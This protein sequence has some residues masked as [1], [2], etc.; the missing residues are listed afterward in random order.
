[1][2][3]LTEG[4]IVHYVARKNADHAPALIVRVVDRDPVRVNL[5][6][7]ASSTTQASR[8]GAPV[9]IENDVP[10]SD[11]KEPFSWHWIERA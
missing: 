4:R 9:Q 1:M 8:W 7:F 11:A 6:V 5:C 2:E 10:Y 3:G